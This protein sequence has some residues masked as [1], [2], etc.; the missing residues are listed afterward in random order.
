VADLSRELSERTEL[1][2][3]MTDLEQ[4]LKDAIDF[5]VLAESDAELALE[6]QDQL[7]EIADE[8]RDLEE[9]AVLNGPYDKNNVYLTIAAGVGGTEAQDWAEMLLRMYLRYFEKKGWLVEVIQTIKGEEAGIKSAQLLVKGKLVYGY[10][11]REK[12]VHRLVRQSPFNA[13]NLRQTSFAKVEI[14]PQLPD[15]A[16]IEIKSEEIVFET[17]R[18]SGAG[19]QK[20][21]KT[22]SAV[23]LRH[24]PTGL[25]VECQTQRSQHQNK[26]TALS[27]LRS[28]LL[29]IK[30][31]EQ[32][33]TKQKIKGKTV[34]S[35][36]GQQIR[37]YVLHPYK[38][39]K[40]LRTGYEETNAQ[41][42]LDGKLDGFIEAELSLQ[43]RSL[44]KYFKISSIVI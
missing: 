14:I 21:N 6:Y 27:L 20:V 31:Q 18:S 44:L 40:D 28:K 12:G 13:N 11:K 4:K 1:V 29:A 16:N 33:Q 7:T 8:I 5:K 10:L 37:S 23:R 15:D 26:A 42:I 39:V 17:F 30:L 2:K 3:T 34:A 43:N 25:A 22:S 35:D 41:A 9:A 38:L 36:W 19:G 24:L 32:E